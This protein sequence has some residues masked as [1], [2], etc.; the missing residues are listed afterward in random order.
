M[1]AQEGENRPVSGQ[2]HGVHNVRMPLQP[3][4]W[5]WHDLNSAPSVV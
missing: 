4:A 3:H 5:H 1:V 2:L